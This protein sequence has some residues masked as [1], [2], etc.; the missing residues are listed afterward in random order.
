MSEAGSLVNNMVVRF[1]CPV[2]GGRVL[3]SVQ[4]F[5]QAIVGGVEVVPTPVARVS[6]RAASDA[7]NGYAIRAAEIDLTLSVV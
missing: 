1:G 7:I 6:G 3:S 5:L 4:Q 2:T